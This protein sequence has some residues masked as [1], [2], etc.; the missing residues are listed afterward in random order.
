ME[1][2]DQPSFT[3]IA[4]SAA[5]YEQVAT[6]LDRPLIIGSPLSDHASFWIPAVTGS[7]AFHSAWIWY[8]RTPDYADQTRVADI[9]S[10]LALDFL[11]RHALTMVLVA[12][13]DTEDLNLARSMPHLEPI[14]ADETGGYAIFRV[15]DA[16]PSVRGPVTISD[17]EVTSL[18]LSRE[19]L[20]AGIHANEPTEVRIAINDYPAWQATIDG[21]EVPIRRSDDGYMLVSVPAGETELDLT[22]SIEPVV[23]VG[24][25]LTLL[26]AALL[27]G[28]LIASLIGRRRVIG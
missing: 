21:R 12:T 2:T 27:A 17:G 3:A 20:I 24:R 6:P 26:G 11:H 7:N 15:Q 13:N 1:T 10:A 22:Y 8:W 19:R 28:I 25:V 18:N 23:W 5:T 16:G 14:D 4:R 9:E